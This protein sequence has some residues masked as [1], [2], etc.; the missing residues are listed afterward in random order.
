MHRR[1]AY[2]RDRW[3]A[4]LCGH[5][6]RIDDILDAHRNPVQRPAPWLRIQMPRL[7][8]H[9]IGV[10]EGPC[11]NNRLALSDALEACAGDRFAIHLAGTYRRGNF[12]RR[13]LVQ[14]PVDHGGPSRV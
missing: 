12:G 4:H 1:E 8:K 5:V 7:S 13:K 11:T 10:E 9:E 3:R 6:T 14:R 2:S